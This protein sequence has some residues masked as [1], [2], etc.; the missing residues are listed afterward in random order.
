MRHE[1]ITAS[2]GAAPVPEDPA[3]PVAA[4]PIIG[5]KPKKGEGTSSGGPRGV[6][7]PLKNAL[8]GA[9]C[10]STGPARR[11]SGVMSTREP[12]SSHKGS[13]RIFADPMVVPGA[14][15]ACTPAGL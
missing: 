12:L 3:V 2:K 8:P 5:T 4:P 10:G 6:M 1:A 14:T 11:T 13:A 9:A 15:C 7:L